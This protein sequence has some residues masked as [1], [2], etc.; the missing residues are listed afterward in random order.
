MTGDAAPR[1]PDLLANLKRSLGVLDG[2]PAV[3]EYAQR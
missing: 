2:L 3:A 1:V